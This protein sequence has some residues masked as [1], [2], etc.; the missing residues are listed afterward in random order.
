[1][2]IAAGHLPPTFPRALHFRLSPKFPLC[3]ALVLAA[4]PA[5]AAPVH[6]TYWEKWNGFEQRAMQAV[7]DKFNASQDRI[8]VDYYDQT[9][10]IDRKTL[11]VDGRRRPAGPRRAPRAEHRDLCRR[12]GA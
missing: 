1:V 10:E 7:I 11:V 6:V 3:A 4:L 2:Q 8:V 5:A 9:G 12:R